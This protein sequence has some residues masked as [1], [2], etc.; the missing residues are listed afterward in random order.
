MAKRK[1]IKQDL[2][3]QIER[4]GI[5]GNHYLDLIEDY[6]NFY[7]IKIELVKD[8]KERGVS[9]KYQHGQNQWG[10]KKNESVAELNRVNTQMM[11]I[12]N[13][14]KIKPEPVIVTKKEDDNFEL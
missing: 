1:D 8:I 3:D 6:I 10:Y 13:D 5:I 7:D 9:I 11:K 12:L 2:L 14:L 4:M